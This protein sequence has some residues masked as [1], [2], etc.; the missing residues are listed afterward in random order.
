MTNNQEN[1]EFVRNQVARL[2]GKDFAPT[3][4]ALT[5]VIDTLLA[6][7]ETTAHA[8][9]IVDE[10]LIESGK[11]PECAIF[12]DVAARTRN[13]E[14]RFDPQCRVCSCGW[15]TVPFVYRFGAETINTTKVARC[16]CWAWRA[17]GQPEYAFF[18][19]RA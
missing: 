2:G 17:K 18:G 6:C 10:L 3:G 4:P 14:F 8:K 9:L 1:R 12:R 13:L 19:D 7:S 16:G 5:E 15:V 11:F